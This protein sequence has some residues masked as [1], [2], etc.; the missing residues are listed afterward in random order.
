MENKNI[1]LIKKILFAAIFVLGLWLIYSNTSQI[2]EFSAL[3]GNAI[4][5]DRRTV[6]IFITTFGFVGFFLETI[7]E[8]LSRDHKKEG[9]K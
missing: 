1:T 4:A 5:T 7:L 9:N 8:K 6:Y 3:T 2:A